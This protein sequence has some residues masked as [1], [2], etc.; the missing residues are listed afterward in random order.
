MCLPP[1][2][3]PLPLIRALFEDYGMTNGRKIGCGIC[4]N[5]FAIYTMYSERLHCEAGRKWFDGEHEFIY[6]RLVMIHSFIYY[7]AR[8]CINTR[9][10]DSINKHFI[11]RVRAYE[12]EVRARA[13]TRLNS[14]CVCEHFDHV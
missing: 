9:S 12:R 3:P 11:A 13:Y 4:A 5:V 8:V 14:M 7:V 1:T 2:S 6:T 10:D